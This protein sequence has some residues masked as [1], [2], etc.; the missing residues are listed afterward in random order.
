MSFLNKFIRLKAT[1]NNDPYVNIKCQNVLALYCQTSSH[2]GGM[3]IEQI[4][5]ER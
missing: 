3:N 4:F 1:A 2:S 5:N